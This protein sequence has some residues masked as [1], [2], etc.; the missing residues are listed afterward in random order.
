VAFVYKQAT[1]NGVSLRPWDTA[2]AGNRGSYKQIRYIV[3]F[4]LVGNDNA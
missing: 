2:A 1:P 4:Q 3:R